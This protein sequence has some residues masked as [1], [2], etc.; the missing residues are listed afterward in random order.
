MPKIDLTA[1]KYEMNDSTKRYA[2][3]KLTNLIKYLPRHS[4]KS[5]TIR[6]NLEELSKNRDDKFQVEIFV[7][8]PDKVLTVT[9]NATNMT[10]AI[11][12]AESK[13]ASQIRKY[14]TEAMPHVSKRNRVRELKERF[15]ASRAE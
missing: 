9:G 6:A 2:Q 14:K 7:A 11:D 8:V 3:K 5:A 10:A 4:R 12:I 13:M 1:L 15:L